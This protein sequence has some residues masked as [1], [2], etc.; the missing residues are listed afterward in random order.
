MLKKKLSLRLPSLSVL[1]LLVSA[2]GTTTQI[3]NTMVC[4]SAGSLHNGAIC[5]ETITGNTSDMTF[6]MFLDFLEPKEA[7]PFNPA[8]SGAICQSSADWGKQKTALEQ[9]CR[10]MGARCSYEIKQILRNMSLLQLR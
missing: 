4:T 1:A 2:C 8:R 10:A 3:P 6:E 7:G 9:A 5:A